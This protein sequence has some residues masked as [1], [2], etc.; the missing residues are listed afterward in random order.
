MKRS[1]INGLIALSLT[2]VLAGCKQA[3]TTEQIFVNPEPGHAFST[4]HG[5]VRLS[6]LDSVSVCYTLDGSQ[7][8]VV[9]G[10]C[11]GSSALYDSEILLGC[12]GTSG[13]ESRQVRIGFDWPNEGTL[14]RQ[15]GFSLN[16]GSDTPLDDSDN[17][18]VA[19][20][21]DNCPLVANS[22]Q[23]D[24]D[25]D[26]IGD[27]CDFDRDNDAIDDEYDNCPDVANNDQ[28]DTDQ[29]GMGDACDPVTDSDQDGI[30]DADDNCPT[31]PNAD[32]NDIDGNGIGDACEAVIDDA[33][34]DGILDVDD[35][36][37]NTANP[38]QAD[39]D[40]DGIGNACDS[41][42]NGP[43]RDGDTIP[44][45]E[46]NCPNQPNQNQADSDQ[47]GIGDAC[48]TA[49]EPVHIDGL[50]VSPIADN[51]IIDD[52]LRSATGSTSAANARGDNLDSYLAC[53]NSE[54]LTY[55]PFNEYWVRKVRQH[56]YDNVNWM[57]GGIGNNHTA[58]RNC[59]MER[60]IEPSAITVN[61]DYEEQVVRHCWGDPVEAEEALGWMVM[62]YMSLPPG[63]SGS[64]IV[65]VINGI[66]YTID[67]I[68]TI[69]DLVE[70]Y[71][72]NDGLG[73]F[74]F[75]PRAMTNYPEYVQCLEERKIPGFDFPPYKTEPWSQYK[76]W[77]E[78]VDDYCRDSVVN[79]GIQGQL[80]DGT[81]WKA[82]DLHNCYTVRQYPEQGAPMPSEGVTLSDWIFGDID[83]IEEMTYDYAYS[84]CRQVHEPREKT[85]EFIHCLQNI[86]AVI[87]A[88][89]WQRFGGWLHDSCAA[90]YPENSRGANAN[91]Y[92][93]CIEST[94]FNLTSAEETLLASLVGTHCEN[95]FYPSGSGAG[96]YENYNPY[97]TCYSER[98]YSFPNNASWKS[99]VRDYCAGSNGVN[100]SGYRTC[101]T[102]RDV[103]YDDNSWKTHVKQH[104]D[105]VPYP[106][107]PT[108]GR[109]EDYNTYWNCFRAADT[110]YINDNGWKNG[111]RN[112]CARVNGVNVNNYK[113]CLSD[114]EVGYSDNIWKTHV[115]QHCDGASYPGGPTGGR[116]EDYNTYWNCFRNA[117]TTYI[118]DGGWKTGVRNFCAQVNVGGGAN[119]YSNYTS[120]ISARQVPYDSGSWCAEVEEHCEAQWYPFGGKDV[121]YSERQCSM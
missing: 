111:V 26:G 73:L 121:C 52:C 74:D 19:D 50:T 106:G 89:Q 42:P 28:A 69:G 53:L 1:H 22:Q 57:A 35:N 85:S 65:N 33:D 37:P 11:D 82:S 4:D 38:G 113:R 95:S 62:I 29:D 63:P 71:E 119:A 83:P 45:N 66:T 103:P 68:D 101:L 3:P 12:D 25:N 9:S 31:V 14:Y 70:H 17:D 93:D 117:G 44:D 76:A 108:G 114:R 92:R 99:N 51:I 79:G 48:D 120:C 115:K 102:Q 15:A 41:T 88:D 110:T 75:A 13:V 49:Q 32:Q 107:G 23:Y 6:A 34:F 47:D 86:G 90:R 27:A 60:G 7:P 24:T 100:V 59:I 54:G 80:G 16:C 105:S 112:F 56:C 104:C 77:T 43:D 18:G 84:S 67:M 116:F 5:T 55:D 58:Y 8:V 64:T 94:G 10:G 91:A 87:P 78:I 2:A 40:G 98:G 39:N 36:C 81:G 61:D 97:W 118:N 96:K 30:D 72:D 109:F 20:D 21:F 46:D